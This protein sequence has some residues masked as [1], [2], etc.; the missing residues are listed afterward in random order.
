MKQEKKSSVK[1]MAQAPKGIVKTVYILLVT[2]KSYT[3]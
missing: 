1:R 3:P 2:K